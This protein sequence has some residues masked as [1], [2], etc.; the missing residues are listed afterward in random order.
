MIYDIISTFPYL[1][2]LIIVIEV[3]VDGNYPF[4]DGI[5]NIIVGLLINHLDVHVFSIYPLCL[6]SMIVKHLSYTCMYV[7]F[8]AISVL[9]IIS[10]ESI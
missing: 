5:R 6:S 8:P 4:N 2:W 1:M 10:T 3:I 7:S 9:E